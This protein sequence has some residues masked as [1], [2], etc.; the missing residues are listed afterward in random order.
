MMEPM[1]ER[2]AAQLPEMDP[3]TAQETTAT[4]PRPPLI[5]PTNTS[6]KFTRDVPIPP[7][8]IIPPTMINSGMARSTMELIWL[9]P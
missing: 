9:N 2:V 1:H 6:T 7:L 5:R 8:S 4:T 3:N